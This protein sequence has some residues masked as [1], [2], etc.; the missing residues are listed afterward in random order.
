MYITHGFC[1][2]QDPSK[3]RKNIVPGLARVSFY[4]TSHGGQV[5]H[6]WCLSE[7]VQSCHAM[8][9]GV[10]S[11][12]KNINEKLIIMFASL[13]RRLKKKTCK[14]MS[15]LPKCFA[16][17]C[18]VSLLMFNCLVGQKWTQ[19]KTSDTDVVRTCQN[20]TP[21]FHLRFLKLW[22]EARLKPPN[23]P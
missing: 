23:P 12:E 7:M 10:N 5:V 3:F 11:I 16:Y 22:V 4:F 18:H 19:P 13:K 17:R 21:W 9:G 6:R 15:W 8:L 20:C 2:F 14:S 1:S